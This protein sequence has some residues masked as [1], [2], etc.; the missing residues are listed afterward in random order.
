MKNSIKISRQELYEKVWSFPLT[1]LCKEYN[2]SD[3][4]LRKICIKHD[5]PLPV[6]GHW[7]KVRFG[8]K[9]TKIKLPAK[10]ET[11]IIIEIKPFE[12][13][14]S[15]SFK[16]SL[17][18]FPDL[19]LVIPDELNNPDKITK[20]LKQDLSKKK[21]S[22]HGNR[23]NV[24]AASYNLEVPD[25]VISKD[26]LSRALL[27]IDVLIKNFRILGFKVYC[28][29]QG[30]IIEN[31]EGEKKKISLTE[32]STAKIV[33]QGNY[34]WERR[35]FFPNGKLMLRIGESYRMA[36]FTDTATEPIENKIRKILLRVL[37]NFEKEKQE[38][39]LSAIHH[40]GRKEEEEIRKIVR[41]LKEDEYQR[42]INFYNEAERWK[43]F[44]VLKEFYDYKKQ[45]NPED[46]NWLEWAKK[47]LDWYDPSKNVDDSLLDEVDKNTLELRKRNHWGN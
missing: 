33:V 12:D 9:V 41:K 40:A 39:F 45:V 4:G 5:I 35:L 2:L 23:E 29:L 22:S 1:Q 26:N 20:A 10:D 42:F 46:K 6:S 14:S 47:K 31:D 28:T 43:K 16:D 7:S 27:I 11:N 18:E 37:H 8:K 3:N 25:V 15:Q 24:I 17:S 21:P 19:I 38:R 32:K 30:L 34:N 44:M 13:K 36:E